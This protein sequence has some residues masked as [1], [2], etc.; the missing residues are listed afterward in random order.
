MLAATLTSVQ[1]CLDANFISISLMKCGTYITVHAAV[2]W[3][4]RHNLKQIWL[5]MNATLVISYDSRPNVSTSLH[6]VF[7]RGDLKLLSDALNTL[8]M[9]I[10]FILLYK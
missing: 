7:I 5:K 3:M 8:K 2:R 4:I 1:D 9:S 10:N 6:S